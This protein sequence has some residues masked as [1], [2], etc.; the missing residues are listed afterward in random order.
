MHP[1]SSPR[2]ACVA[3]AWCAGRGRRRAWRHLLGAPLLAALAACGGG[4]GAAAS[5]GGD[6]GPVVSTLS[7]AADASVTTALGRL[8]NNTWNRAAVGS[9]AWRQCLQRRVQAGSTELGWTWQW[10]EGDTGVLAYPS[11]VIGA[12]PWE[13]G[14]GNDARFPV[15][16]A[17]IGS[18][19]LRYTL[20]T[21]A[22]GR[23]NL[24]TSLWLINTPTVGSPPVTTAITTELMVWTR[25]SGG[26]WTGG[27]QPF[28]EV[29]L[30]GR[31]W[32]VYGRR[33]QSDASGGSVHTW[34][35]L[36]Y[37]AA[38]P[39]D[40]LDL[41]LKLVLDDAIARGWVNAADHVADV[42]LGNEIAGGSGSTWI[43]QFS[44]E[45]R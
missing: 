22:S 26:D 4:G 23:S 7:C 11:L 3:P 44:L 38:D 18:L 35:L 20:D 40:T 39:S 42:E 9:Q 10:P 13:A 41:D 6:N 28:A 43:R 29:T 30:G 15:P 37:A 45:L 12:K 21:T 17:R 16:I 36:V 31:R 34:T 32:L 1:C 5:G 24:A 8:H 25:A 33:D 19:R 2:P 14:P 27:T